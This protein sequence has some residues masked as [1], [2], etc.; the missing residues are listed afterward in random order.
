MKTPQ[1]TEYWILIVKK[2]LEFFFLFAL[3]KFIHLFDNDFAHST[4]K[5]VVSCTCRAFENS[6][7]I[8]VTWRSSFY[9]SLQYGPR[10]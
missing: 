8:G 4:K 1:N 3:I 10:G 2:I 7:Y 9:N 6:F 5:H